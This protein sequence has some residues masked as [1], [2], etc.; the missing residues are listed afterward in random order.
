MCILEPLQLFECVELVGF[1]A[2]SRLT[3]AE[4]SKENPGTNKELFF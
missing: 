3:E 2:E 1:A 4:A